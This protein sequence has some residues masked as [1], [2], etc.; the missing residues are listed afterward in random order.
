MYKC[1]YIYINIVDSL[2]NHCN[3]H[4]AL[5]SYIHYILS[6]FA[7]H[8]GQNSSP[9]ANKLVWVGRNNK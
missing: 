5:L 4:L 8:V 1:I 7:K 3:M 6:I 2:L 9:H